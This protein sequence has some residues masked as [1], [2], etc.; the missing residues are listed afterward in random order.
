MSQKLDVTMLVIAVRTAREILE[1]EAVN[2]RERSEPRHEQIMAEERAVRDRLN[3]WGFT[4]N[5]N[6]SHWSVAFGNV[7]ATSTIGACSAVNNWIAAV[8]RKIGAL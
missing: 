5:D 8:E 7:R 2:R 6:F 4:V 3:D 1:E